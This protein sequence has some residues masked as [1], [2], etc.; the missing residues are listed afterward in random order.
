MAAG[1]VVQ[2]VLA[3]QDDGD[4]RELLR[5]DVQQQRLVCKLIWIIAKILMDVVS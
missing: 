2:V 5:L 3:L 1:S 4:R